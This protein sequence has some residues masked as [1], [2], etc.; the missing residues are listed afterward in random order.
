MSIVIKEKRTGVASSC[1]AITTFSSTSNS[2]FSA[3]MVG[4][5]IPRHTDKHYVT[6]LQ[7]FLHW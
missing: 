7:R 5:H 3:Y 4:Q 6:M 2:T 1:N